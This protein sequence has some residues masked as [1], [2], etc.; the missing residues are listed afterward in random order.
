[1]FRQSLVVVSPGDF[2]LRA[3]FDAVNHDQIGTAAGFEKMRVYVAD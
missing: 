3:V 2:R 1:L